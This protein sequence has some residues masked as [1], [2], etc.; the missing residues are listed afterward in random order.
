MT[1]QDCSDG[2]A[3]SWAAAGRGGYTQSLPPMNVLGWGTLLPHSSC[4]LFNSAKLS[5]WQRGP[6]MAGMLAQSH[7]AASS[8]VHTAFE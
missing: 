1:Q 7:M 3:A 8:A 5:C 4:V 6:V 2:F